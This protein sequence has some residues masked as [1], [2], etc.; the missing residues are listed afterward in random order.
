MDPVY[1]KQGEPRLFIEHLSQQ[2]LHIDVWDGDSLLLI[3]SCAVQLQVMI[4]WEVFFKQ[5]FR[6]ELAQS[7]MCF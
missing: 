6:V 4:V 1:M 7:E 3:G 2:T 5:D